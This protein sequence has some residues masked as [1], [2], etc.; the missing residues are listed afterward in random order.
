MTGLN[1]SLL[2]PRAAKPLDIIIVGAGIAGLSTAI[3]LHKSGHSIV[4]LEQVH[5]IGEVGAGI[6][7]APNAARILRRFGLLEQVMQKANVL[8]A[9]SLR[10][11]E[12]DEVLGSAKMMPE[13]SI[14]THIFRSAGQV[15]NM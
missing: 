1:D 5:E 4:I 11:W 12:N 15:C 14:I 2:L 13:V 10:R 6:Q 8:E 7:I 9:L 3:G